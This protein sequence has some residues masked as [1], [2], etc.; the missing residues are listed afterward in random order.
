MRGKRA[1]KSTGKVAGL[2]DNQTGVGQ[3]TG[4][5][6]EKTVAKE[7]EGKASRLPRSNG[8]VSQVLSGEVDT[9]ITHKEAADG[10]PRSLVLTKGDAHT[11][12]Y[13]FGTNSEC[14]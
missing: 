13:L 4:L 8:P 10:A 2:G 14:A 1:V 7:A 9:P 12:K 11:C 3:G 6:R 5:I